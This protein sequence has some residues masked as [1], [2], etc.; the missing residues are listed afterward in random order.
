MGVKPEL[1]AE[2]NALLCVSYPRRRPQI[3]GR[4]ERMLVYEFA[5]SAVSSDGAAPDGPKPF[6][7]RKE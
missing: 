1:Q 3:A 6:A 7:P 2:V 5:S 4:Q